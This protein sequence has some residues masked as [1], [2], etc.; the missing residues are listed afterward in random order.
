ML[1][2]ASMASFV[3]GAAA[4]AVARRVPLYG[5]KLEAAAGYVFIVGFLLIGSALPGLA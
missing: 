5:T 4:I 1:A 2:I 3:V